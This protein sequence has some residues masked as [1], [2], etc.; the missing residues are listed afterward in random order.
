[1]EGTK[2]FKPGDLQA[3]WG[4]VLDAAEP[5][6]A[7]INQA[8]GEAE[9]DVVIKGRGAHA[10]ANP[11]QGL[12]AIR[13]AASFI[14]NLPPHRL[15]EGAA[16]NFGI[17]KGG[18]ATNTICPWVELRGEIRSYEDSERVAIADR[19]ERILAKSLADSGGAYSLRLRESYS[20]YKV[21]ADHSLI[22]LLKR[23]AAPLGV[24]VDVHPRFAGS[25]AN[26]LNSLGL[27]VV[28]LGLGVE[29]NH[30]FGERASISSLTVMADWLQ[31]ILEEWRRG[32][33]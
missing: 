29:G 20:A 17:I 3:R 32:R 33:A 16:Y 24:T 23:T 12:D 28:N 2:T 4:L 15:S 10:A 13:L 22:Q 9:L 7:V 1:M 11:E 18:K 26:I 19:L 8:P 27:T 14:N 25:D 30:S 31:G 6:G 21:E 5:V